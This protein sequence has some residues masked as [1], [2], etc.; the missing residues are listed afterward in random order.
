MAARRSPPVPFVSTLTT[1]PD[2]GQAMAA[3]YGIGNVFVATDSPV[4]PAPACV[5]ACVGAD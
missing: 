5:R 3:R 1:G 4:P 2:E